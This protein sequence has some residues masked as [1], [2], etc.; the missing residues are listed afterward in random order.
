MA[1]HASVE[2]APSKR[3]YFAMTSY[4]QASDPGKLFFR[5]WR[6]QLPNL[7]K[8]VIGALSTAVEGKTTHQ[9]VVPP[10]YCPGAIN[11]G[12]AG[13][14]KMD[15]YLKKVL[16]VLNAGVKRKDKVLISTFKIDVGITTSSVRP[17]WTPNKYIDHGRFVDFYLDEIKK[18]KIVKLSVSNPE[19]QAQLDVQANKQYQ[20]LIN[21]TGEVRENLMEIIAKAREVI[22]DA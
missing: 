18:T 3:Q 2:V 5:V 4:S 15:A 9:L 21:Q 8:C 1:Q 19:L 6:S 16:Q 13:S 10:I 14:A 22:A 12:N 17:V 20:L 11:I 7:M